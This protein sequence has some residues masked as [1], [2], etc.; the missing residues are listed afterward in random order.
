MVNETRVDQRSRQLKQFALSLSKLVKEFIASTTYVPTPLRASDL[1]DSKT[2][3]ELYEG[4]KFQSLNQALHAIVN[5]KVEAYIPELSYERARGHTINWFFR[6]VQGYTKP[7]KV[8]SPAKL[9]IDINDPLPLHFSKDEL[10]VLKQYGQ[11]IEQLVNGDISSVT[12][13]QAHFKK[14]AQDLLVIS[15]D[16]R[17]IKPEDFY[18]KLIAKYI[19][20]RR[21]S[22][23]VN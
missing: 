9:H 16:L 21:Y 7:K 11:K 12:E 22:I 19:I 10:D 15:R 3:R 20:C 1:N 23:D 4:Y 14:V 6:S 17:D 18:Q 8:T 13:A 5:A 2:I